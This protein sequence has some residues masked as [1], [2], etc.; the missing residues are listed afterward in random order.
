DI[1]IVSDLKRTKRIGTLLSQGKLDFETI[2]RNNK[3]KNRNVEVEA[4]LINY[5]DLPA[6][7]NITRDI[8]E[9]KQYEENTRKAQESLTTIL[10]AI[11]DL[12]FEVGFDGKIYHFQTH[13]Q[14]LL[15]V[16]PNEIMGKFFQDI[17]PPDA[18]E[19]CF[20]AMKEANKNGWSTG[21]Q[22]SLD[23]PQG[24][25]WFELSVS[26]IKES[27]D[28]DKHYIFLA[29]DVTDR[30]LADEK[31]RNEK[32]RIK[33]ILEMV[34]NP[35][36]LK[37]N[38]HK[39]TYANRLFF[40]LFELD[41][42]SVINKTLVENVPENEREHF[43]KIDRSVLDTGIPDCRE[44]ELTV[45]GLVHTII[46]SKTR[47]I[48]ESGNKML[49]GS[50]H[51]ITERKLA[52]QKILSSEHFLNQTQIIANLGSYSLDFS[53]GKWIS[54]AVLDSIFGIE[55]TYEKTIES[56]S[57]I[58]HPDWTSIMIDYLNN[59]VI[60]GKNNFNKEYKII[61]IDS[62]E[63][64]WVHGIGEITF[65]KQG[66]PL[67]L[68]GSIQDITNRKLTEEQIKISEQ[69]YHTLFNT[70]TDCI[71]IH[72]PKTGDILDVNETTIKTFGYNFKEEIVGHSINELNTNIPP[73]TRENALEYIQKT[74]REGNQTFEW[75]SRRKDGSFFWMEMRLKK[76]IL[77][78]KIR[79]LAVGRDITERKQVEKDLQE[80]KEKLQVIFDSVSE[81][82]YVLDETGTF[83]DVNK[84]AEKMYQCSK[85][86]LIG[87]TPLDVAAPG[88]NDLDE[89][90]R[91]IQSVFTNGIPI[92]F[93]F[94]AIR[95]N[96]EI[97]PKEVVINKGKFSDKEVL[98]VTARDISARKKREKELKKTEEKLTSIFNLAN[99][100]IILADL[101]GNFL[102]F[103]DWWLKM[104]GYTAE[105]FGKL[106]N[107]G[108]THPD[109]LEN[110]KLW[111][112]KIING[113]IDKY[114][115]EKRYIKKDKTIFWGESSVS[116]IKDKNNKITSTIGI[117]TDITERKATEEKLK[118]S[119]EKFQDLVNS[120]GGI[121]W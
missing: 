75:L 42:N 87:K 118:L 91:I 59:E 113:E 29:R 57:E 3:G 20:S 9:R 89:V 104:I 101:N 41:E 15:A 114:K 34:G 94:W 46:T 11:P 40:D 52:E 27:S 105:E 2:I 78:G 121:V 90:N 47:F 68:I 82:I 22:Y 55:A 18:T 103:N 69:N 80:N 66:Q 108:V 48:D 63:E 93:E 65:D 117:V 4:L 99:S 102:E 7:M 98:I 1:E 37:D 115:I 30:K 8:T 60:G 79:V 81:A 14:D 53:T 85:E 116:A 21:K 36:F 119:L 54:S 24:K 120:T 109:D 16:S 86:E 50:I 31:L 71:F 76:I 96:G 62:K 39:I 61:K 107:F 83:I 100:G 111:L 106:K 51:D 49:V 33:A 58:I 43:L 19:T 25:H 88:L 13:R 64:R 5:D 84:G 72:D 73:Y 70:S 67:Q 10:E 97:F 35:I 44:E 77:D 32:E 17:L 74:I 38:D 28:N 23:L 12:L 95:K 56:W 26:P 45:N 112:N 92:S 6:V 110:S